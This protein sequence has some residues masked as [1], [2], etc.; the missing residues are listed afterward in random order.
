MQKTYPEAAT[1]DQGHL[2]IDTAVGNTI[3]T[4]FTTAVLAQG[5]WVVTGGILYSP[6]AANRKVTLWVAQGTAV[7]TFDGSAGAEQTALSGGV[8]QPTFDAVVT[9]TTAGTLLIRAQA[10][11]V[12]GS[13]K[14]SATNVAVPNVSGYTALKIG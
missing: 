3:V 7:A 4:L 11:T 13:A 14:A 8:A 5:I 6:G 1:R 12:G 9:I 2:A 10:D